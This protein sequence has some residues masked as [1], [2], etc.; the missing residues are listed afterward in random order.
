MSEVH[1]AGTAFLGL[2]EMLIDLVNNPDVSRIEIVMGSYEADEQG[3]DKLVDGQLSIALRPFIVRG[4]NKAVQD[5]LRKE[6]EA[7]PLSYLM[8]LWMEQFEK[9]NKLGLFLIDPE[10]KQQKAPGVAGLDKIEK[11]AIADYLQRQT[12]R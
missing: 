10:T 8:V 1:P 9:E 5:E 12:K 11:S 3:K 4:M 7:G 6:M 2:I